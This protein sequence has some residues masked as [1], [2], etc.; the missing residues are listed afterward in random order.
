MA[1]YHD[2]KT[3]KTI[4]AKNLQEARKAMAPKAPKKPRKK[5]DD[6]VKDDDSK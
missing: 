4:E 5:A 6:A 1:K 3:K 2:P